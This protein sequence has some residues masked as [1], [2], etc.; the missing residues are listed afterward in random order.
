MSSRYSSMVQ[1]EKL[2]LLENLNDKS[3]Y[4]TSIT[5]IPNLDV[6]GPMSKNQDTQ[7]ANLQMDIHVCV[8]PQI[9]KYIQSKFTCALNNICNCKWIY[10]NTYISDLQTSWIMISKTKKWTNAKRHIPK[11]KRQKQWCRHTIGCPKYDKHAQASGQSGLGSPSCGWKEALPRFD[12]W[13]DYHLPGSGW[14]IFYISFS[15][16]NAHFTLICSLLVLQQP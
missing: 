15:K 1:T 14:R 3:C 2:Y 12:V 11:T 8:K 9:Y 16:D 4:K 10:S 6:L 5:S 13:I 7:I